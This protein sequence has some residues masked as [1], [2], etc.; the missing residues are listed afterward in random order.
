MQ[1]GEVDV[2]SYIYST[3]SA[4]KLLE[5]LQEDRLPSRGQSQE[6]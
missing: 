6:R 3:S 2:G 1:E 4:S 5:D